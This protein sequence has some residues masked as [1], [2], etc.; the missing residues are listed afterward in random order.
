M[1]SD[2]GASHD[3]SRG[4]MYVEQDRSARG[5][6]EVTR[7]VWQCVFIRRKLPVPTTFPVARWDRIGLV[8]GAGAKP[9][10]CLHAGE[11]GC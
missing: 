6:V 3:D 1:N 9:L 11:I 8:T 2:P 5:G 4:L 7:G 10:D